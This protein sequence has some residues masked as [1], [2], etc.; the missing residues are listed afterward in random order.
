MP[1]K[2]GKKGKFYS[3]SID[4]EE[5]FEEEQETEESEKDTW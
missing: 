4:E 1:K 3:R 2:T 5:D